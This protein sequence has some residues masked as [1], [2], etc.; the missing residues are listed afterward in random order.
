MYIPML[1]SSKTILLLLFQ[2]IMMEFEEGEGS[3]P[4]SG[5]GDSG[6]NV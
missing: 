5:V 3:Q 6:C 4:G 1:T 2:N